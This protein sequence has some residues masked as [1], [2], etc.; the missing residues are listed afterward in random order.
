LFETATAGAGRLDPC[1]RYAVL[2]AILFSLPIQ[3][4]VQAPGRPKESEANQPRGSEGISW[5]L[6][7]A[8]KLTDER[9]PMQ[10]KLVIL[11]VAALLTPSLA[12]AQ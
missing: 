6:V 10:K 8:R 4:T 12:I 7:H 1:S 3:T 2:N 11:A 5:E 9:K